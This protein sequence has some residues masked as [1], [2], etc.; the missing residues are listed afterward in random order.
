[1]TP[2]RIGGA[3]MAAAAAGVVV[4][5]AAVPRPAAA[6]LI[7][8]GKLSDA[9]ADLEGVRSCTKCHRLRERGIA[10]DLCLECHTPVRTRVTQGKGYHASLG[11]RNCSDCHKEHFGRDFNVLH[12]DTTAF[13]HQETGFRLE[14]KHGELACRECHQPKLIVAA[15]VKAFKGEHGA[16][17]RTFLGLATTCETCHE[18]DSPHGRQFAGRA[19]TD[20]HTQR[21]WKHTSGF[22]HDDTQY[23]LTGAH[24]DVACQKCHKLA[25]AGDPKSRRYTGIAFRVCTDCHRDPHE[26]RMG[27]DCARC[28]NTGGWQQLPRDAFERD[29]DHGKTKFELR[30]QHRDAR[31]AACHTRDAGG[32]EGIRLTFAAAA[33]NRS[34]PPPDATRCVSCH[35][36]YH[37]GAFAESPGGIE[38]R[39][40]HAE[41]AWLPTT[42]DLERH[43]KAT[44]FELTGAHVVTPCLA[45]H[46]D[47]AAGEEHLV[48]RLEHHE[49]CASCH[50]KND[51]HGTQFAGRACT[52]CH[53]TSAFK[54]KAFDHDRTRYALDGRHRDVPCAS[55]H[56]ERVDADGKKVR[57][58]RPLGM[59]CKDCHGGGA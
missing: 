57:I 8:P 2:R 13:D 50:A 20:C 29:F 4:L 22:D 58:Y 17:D 24:R 36:D 49:D 21:D 51:P 28:H 10:N 1:M 53:E 31:C 30:G 52:D 5:A 18:S 43:N 9:H 33:A 6:Q 12:L 56:I 41:E 11:D 45:C 54:V 25:R 40:C 38:C 23:T 15:D 19:C 16:L 47:A 44:K 7:S 3:L 59:D 32:A 55:C 37:E 39:N 34:Y 27:A 42:Y 14:G 46:R 48:F 26:N 35:L